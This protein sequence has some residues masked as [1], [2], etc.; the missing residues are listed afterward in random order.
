MGQS[1]L[2]TYFSYFENKKT[3]V[4][5]RARERKREG[6]RERDRKREKERYLKRMTSNK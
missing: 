6:E 5:E 2:I 3:R 1:R 4:L